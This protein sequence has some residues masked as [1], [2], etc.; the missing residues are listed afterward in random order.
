MTSPYLVHF[1][2]LF[3]PVI[4]AG[5]CKNHDNINIVIWIIQNKNKNR[6]KMY[7]FFNFYFIKTLYVIHLSHKV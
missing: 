2:A 4:Y 1:K 5:T 7:Y 3:R 6:K